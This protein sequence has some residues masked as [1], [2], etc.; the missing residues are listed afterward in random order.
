MRRVNG[1]NLQSA[2]RAE[3]KIRDFRESEILNSFARNKVSNL[4]MDTDYTEKN[5]FVDGAANPG[6]DETGEINEMDRFPSSSSRRG[7]E[8][9]RTYEETSFTTGGDISDITPLMSKENDEKFKEKF[10]EKNRQRGAEIL[11]SKFPKWDPKN[12]SFNATLNKRGEVEVM[13]SDSQ[14]AVPHV[15]IDVDGN[16]NEREI[17]KSKKIQKSLGPR[18]EDIVETNREEMTRRENKIDELNDSLETA[19]EN[20]R[21]QI[22]ANIEQQQNEISRL[23]AENERI[24]ERMSL[25]DRVKLIFKKYGFTVFAVVSA[26][27]LVIGVIVSNLKKGLTSLGKGIGC[28]LKN[29]GKKIGEISPGMIG[30]I[31]SFVFKTAGEAVGFLAKHAWLLILAAVTIMIEKLKK[32]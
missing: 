25:R 6:Y 20:Q 12:S 9:Y 10:K 22:Y 27:G 17:K 31:A 15:I 8:D 19:S 16:V 3:P 24:E 13:L 7:S 4:K 28:A 23:E 2:L 11:K 21:E 32:K 14:K 18:A 29:I 26:V 5:P 1:Y 30:A